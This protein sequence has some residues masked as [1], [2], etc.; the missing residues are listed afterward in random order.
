MGRRSS[1]LPGAGLFRAVEEYALQAADRTERGNLYGDDGKEPH[2]IL[3]RTDGLPRRGKAA[4]AEINRPPGHLERCR[5][6]GRHLAF[7]V[8]LANA[9]GPITTGTNCL[10]PPQRHGF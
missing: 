10:Q 8:I 4:G 3:P 7:E 9:E 6:M 5:P 2:A 1:E